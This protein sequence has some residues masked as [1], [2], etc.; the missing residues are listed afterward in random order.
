MFSGVYKATGLTRG[1]IGA[2]MVGGRSLELV[3]EHSRFK[4][5]QGAL[6]PGREDQFAMGHYIGYM[7]IN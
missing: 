2:V 5:W 3:S 4:P 6:L 7:L 1:S